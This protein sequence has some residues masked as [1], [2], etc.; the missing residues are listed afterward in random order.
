MA[1]QLKQTNTFGLPSGTLTLRGQSHTRKIHGI[2]LEMTT[3]SPQYFNS[4]GEVI[5]V[6]LPKYRLVIRTEA[7]VELFFDQEG[8][9]G[10]GEPQ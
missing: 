10:V 2:S 1:K 6:G 7:G 4:E 3:Y 5:H 8:L 9:E